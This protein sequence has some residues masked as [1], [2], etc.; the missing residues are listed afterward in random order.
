MVMMLVVVALPGGKKL[1]EAGAADGAGRQ[2][3]PVAGAGEHEAVRN[4]R[5][6]Q[7]GSQRDRRAKPLQ[8]LRFSVHCLPED[9]R[10]SCQRGILRPC[11]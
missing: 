3:D 2:F 11:H 6:Q 7:H 8:S 5:A 10:G 1:D 4:E 9:D